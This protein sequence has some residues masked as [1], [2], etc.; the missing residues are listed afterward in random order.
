MYFKYFYLNRKKYFYSKEFK[1]F[2]HNPL[3]TSIATPEAL[4]INWGAMHRVLSAPHVKFPPKFQPSHRQHLSDLITLCTNLT[5]K[6]NHLLT[7]RDYYYFT[8]S[9]VPHSTMGG[10]KKVV[11]T[12]CLMRNVVHCG[13][14]GF[15]S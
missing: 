8:S 11:Q 9:L 7:Y 15:H 3:S 2:L 14:D 4:T 13:E 12:I 6:Y 5:S 10:G 1:F